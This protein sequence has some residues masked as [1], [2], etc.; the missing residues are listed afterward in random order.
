MLAQPAAT[1]PPPGP[2]RIIAPPP[3][4]RRCLQDYGHRH[5]WMVFIDVDEFL[6][7]K[8][9]PPVQS[10]PDFLKQYERY[11]GACAPGR[12][13]AGPRLGWPGGRPA[14]GG[15]AFC[16][17]AFS[18]ECHVH[19]QTTPHHVA[20]ASLDVFQAWPCLGSPPA[21]FCHCC[22]SHPSPGR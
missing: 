21:A 22:L 17:F 10:L 8:E 20:S 15:V 16:C 3:A 7:F 5:S 6:V 13:Q 14:A 9:G 4:K 18:A 12:G 19:I 2:Q 1:T 11:S